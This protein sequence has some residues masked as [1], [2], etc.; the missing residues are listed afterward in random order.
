MIHKICGNKY[1]ICID[2]SIYVD[3]TANQAFI[4]GTLQGLKM[5]GFTY[6]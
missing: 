1:E 2:S 3:T 4:D 6:Q 5:M